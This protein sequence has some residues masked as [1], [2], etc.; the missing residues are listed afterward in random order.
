[1][2]TFFSTEKSIQEII[3]SFHL[4]KTLFVSSII[5]G[6]AHTGK[7]T[8]A[9]YLFPHAHEVSGRHQKEVEE[10]LTEY[11]EI[12]IHNFELLSNKHQLNFDNKRIIA[13]ADYMGNSKIIDSLFSF[14]YHVP[15]L[16]ERPKDIISLKAYF[17]EEAI[18]TLMLEPIDREMLDIPIDLTANIKSLKKSIFSC[19]SQYNMNEKEIQNVLY[20]YFLKNLEGKDAYKSYLGFYE[21]PLIEAGLK[22]FSSQLKLAEVLGINR[23]TLR[24]KIHA[25]NID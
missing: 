6:E 12:I 25:Q 17:I 18:D 23:N 5:I 20:Q 14:I 24:K 1:M 19:L 22:K 16:E 4:T 2:K 13:T 10:A 9:R 21:I 11:D 3:Q 8:L 7:K 15:R